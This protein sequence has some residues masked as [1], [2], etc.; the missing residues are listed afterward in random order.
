MIPLSTLQFYSTQKS[1][2][3][4]TICTKDTGL[5]C[6]KSDMIYEK[7]LPSVEFKGNYILGL[8]N[9]DRNRIWTKKFDEAFENNDAKEFLNFINQ[10]TKLKPIFTTTSSHDL[11][12]I[13]NPKNI[14]N[15][16]LGFLADGDNLQSEITKDADNKD[17]PVKNISLKT[18]NET[19]NISIIATKTGHIQ[20]NNSSLGNLFIERNSFENESNMQESDKDII[21]DGARGFDPFDQ[22]D[23]VKVIGRKW[24][25][26][27]N[28]R[29]PNGVATLST[30]NSQKAILLDTNAS[31]TSSYGTKPR[32]MAILDKE[33]NSVIL[34][35]QQENKNS[36]ID[37]AAWS[38]LPFKIREGKKTVAIFPA[39][40]K[41]VQN[42]KNPKNDE[43]KEIRQS[44]QWG[45]DENNFFVVD[46]SKPS[47]KTE[48]A[49]PYADWCLFATQGEDT[50]CLVRS[51]YKD[52]TDNKQ[53]K[54]FSGQEDLGGTK[55][56]E[57]EFIAPKVKKNQKSTLVYRIE[58][59]S[60]KKLGFDSLNAENMN[61]QI[62]E[63][64]KTI[65][66]KINWTKTL[67]NL[68]F[69][70]T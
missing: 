27:D 41:T 22:E 63:I 44:N 20:I 52:N 49:D 58:F 43:L 53:F 30:D 4:K 21:A 70:D 18:Q 40:K 28:T 35:F 29:D 26:A 32:A 12:D 16:I 19:D 31:I 1:Y 51:C 8:D 46:V 2:T 13:L 48:Y 38:I 25:T 7:K 69:T 42:Y 10:R 39:D 65:E 23:W 57:L 14:L 59:I 24:P 37:F 68:T 54:V 50:A 6:Q 36:D 34:A 56:F 60:L 55:Y 64:G 17:F 3:P 47:E 45:I 61:S 5:Y 62:K 9:Q 15:P 67:S 66:N 11:T 33:N